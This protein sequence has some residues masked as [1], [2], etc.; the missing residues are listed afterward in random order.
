MAENKKIED[1][2]AY[3]QIRRGHHNKLEFA[4]KNYLI[5]K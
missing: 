1:K 5:G 3:W 4:K 2:E